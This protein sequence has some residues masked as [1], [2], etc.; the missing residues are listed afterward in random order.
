MSNESHPVFGER[1]LGT[2]ETPEGRIVRMYASEKS[3]MCVA[4]SAIRSGVM[5]SSGQSCSITCRE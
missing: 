4:I 2:G 5:S 1:R 3:A